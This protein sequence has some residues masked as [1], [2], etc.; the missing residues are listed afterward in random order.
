M[1]KALLKKQFMEMN[2]WLLQNRKTG[3]ART[4]RAAAALG[5][6]YALLIVCLGVFFFFLSKQICAPLHQLGL[7]WLYFV[8]A[9]L[10]AIAMGVFGSVFN[11]YT[12]LYQAKDND[13]LLSLPIRPRYILLARLSGVWFWGTVFSGMIFLPALL[14]YWT[15]GQVTFGILLSG[16]LLLLT[17]SV[18]V[19]VLSCLLGWV[20]AKLS[21][22]LKNK[23][24]IT[25]LISVIFFAIY[26]YVYFRAEAL[27]Q[28]L[29]ANALTVGLKI[30]SSAYPLYAFGR[31]G[32]GRPLFLLGVCA[33]A[34]LLLALAYLLLSHSFLRLATTNY[35]AAKRRYTE[36][37]T[38]CKSV[39]RA[40]LGREFRHYLSSPTY[41]LNCSLG[42][43]FL[44]GIAIAAIVKRDSLQLLAEVLPDGLTVLLACG[45]LCMLAAMNDL[46]AP[47][48]SLE[49]K[50]IWLVQT[51][52]VPAWQALEAKLRL[53]LILTLPFTLLCGVCLS[54]VFALTA[55]DALLMLAASALFVL[56]SAVFGLAVNLKTPNLKWTNET[57]AVKQGAAVIVS[58]FGSWAAVILLGFGY[59][60]LRNAL[61]A[62]VFLGLCSIVLLLVSAALLL[63]IRRH[64]SKI[65]ATLR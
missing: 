39:R 13:L 28:K 10:A 37:L 22:R 21:T 52:P 20:V 48:V 43:L 49:G 17:V 41:M 24:I 59:Y 54:A 30:R 19:L 14:V 36:R 29:V 26:Y 4:K 57:V 65:F 8:I 50:S 60:L 5:F 32:E 33:A 1:L 44:P 15:V 61:T 23:S 55:A 18:L 27:L 7:D 58:L 31:A 16:L 35:G 53:H 25:V 51:L 34:A 56:F 62:R 38:K 12:S 64:G 40:L 47:S 3:K 46:T 9:G 11:T 42:V 63:W 6:S 2:A 45:I